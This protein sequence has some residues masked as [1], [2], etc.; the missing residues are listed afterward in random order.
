M[1]HPDT[2]AASGRPTPGPGL[3]PDSSPLSLSLP[4]AGPAPVSRAVGVAILLVV[5]F[6]WGTTFVATR[7][8]VTG[9][10]PALAPGAATFWRF[11]VAS[12]AIL[13]FVRIRPGRTG[14]PG[15]GPTF[16]SG[17]WR[18]GA[19]LSFWLWAGYATQAVGL[20]YTTVSRSAFVTSLNVV[21]VPLLTAVAGRRVGA[22]VWVAAGLALGGAGLLSY[23]GSPPNAGDAWTLACAAAFAAYIVRLERFAVRFP[24]IPLTA[25]QLWGVTAMSLPWMAAEATAGGA[26]WGRWTVGV[27]VAIA[28]MGVVATLATTWLQA[29]GQRVVPGTHASLLYTTEPV[30]A[31]AIAIAWFGDHLGA[32][33]WA[34]A[35]LILVAAAG[36]QAVPMWRGRGK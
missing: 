8:L 36:S 24:T 13:P 31:S 1:Q 33:G 35:G 19:E 12:V 11:A 34:G 14:L 16:P 22:V 6:V 21:F 7:S 9:E 28:Y 29:V 23:D 2:L 27:A 32:T 30:F 18:A 5:T 25:V 10:A 4:P 20:Q 15:S 17:V 3:V 26:G